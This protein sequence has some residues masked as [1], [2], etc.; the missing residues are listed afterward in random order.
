ME[1]LF[2]LSRGHQS[3]YFFMKNNMQMFSS[4]K[5]C[6]FLKLWSVP[7]GT[8]PRLEWKFR[9]KRGK[10]FKMFFLVTS[11]VCVINRI[12]N[13]QSK[14]VCEQYGLQSTKN[15]PEWSEDMHPFWVQV[16]MFHPK[17]TLL[18]LLNTKLAKEYYARGLTRQGTSGTR[19]N[20]LLFTR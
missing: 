5:G 20:G 17:S 10:Y 8:E 1:I 14:K 4:R 12:S 18:S 15:L 2:N 16:F 19:N 13:I 3:Y 9:N 6:N 11:G 7:A